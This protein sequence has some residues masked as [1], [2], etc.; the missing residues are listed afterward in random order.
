[1]IMLSLLVLEVPVTM[2]QARVPIWKDSAFWKLSVVQYLAPRAP[3]FAI[4][5]CEAV[6][7]YIDWLPQAQSPGHQIIRGNHSCSTHVGLQKPSSLS[8]VLQHSHHKAS[9][10]RYS[11]SLAIQPTAR[12]EGHS[13]RA[14]SSDLLWMRLMIGNASF[15]HAFNAPTPLYFC[16][17]AP[18]SATR[19]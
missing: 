18:G 7:G 14:L 5:V 15:C 3:T 11:N 19:H 9:L 16:T 1:M 17:P 6:A 8:I 2:P 13:T 4:L 10:S 12:I